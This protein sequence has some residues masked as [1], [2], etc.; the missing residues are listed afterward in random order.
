M[1]ALST[2]PAW[3]TRTHWTRGS[4]VPASQATRAV[5]SV[6]PSEKLEDG[7]I[8]TIETL[9]GVAQR[10]AST[11]AARARQAGSRAAVDRRDDGRRVAARL[12]LDQV[13]ERR[14]LGAADAE[15]PR[16]QRADHQEHD[17]AERRSG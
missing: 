7:L 12:G 2:L 11:A 8:W 6:P 13:G 14:V 17:D 10:G 1:K 4:E 16:E 9:P 5:P 15:R 3:R